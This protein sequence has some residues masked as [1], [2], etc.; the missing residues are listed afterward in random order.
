MKKDFVKGIAVGCA[1]SMAIG[2]ASVLADTYRT[3][4]EAVYN[5]IKIVVNGKQI[6]PK[7]GD[8]NTVEPFISGGTTYLPVR[9]VSNALGQNVDWDSNTN[10]V[11][12][13]NKSETNKVDMST[14][15]AFEGISFET[16]N[17]A[18]FTLRQN[19]VTPD[20]R[21]CPAFYKS[22]DYDYTTKYPY[23]Y[24]LFILDSK[25]SLIEGLFALPDTSVSGKEYAIQLVNEDT[26]EVLTTVS[27]KKGEKAVDVKANLT[28][29]DKLR[30]KTG[31]ID[32]DGN[33]SH[34]YD[35]CYGYFYNVYLTPINQK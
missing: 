2:G 5:D 19:T 22:D 24:P 14:I 15:Q 28:G 26:D 13:T 33:F 29:V 4:L 12:I 25:Y 16:G 8:G 18:V 20:N 3:Q 11:Y 27:N 9:A 30:I 31:I 32:L 23:P 21:L 10:T 1:L 6:I 34:P 7:D 17:Y 35:T